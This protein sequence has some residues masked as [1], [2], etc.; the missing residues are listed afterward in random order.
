MRVLFVALFSVFAIQVLADKTKSFKKNGVTVNV[1][2]KDSKLPAGQL[3]KLASTFLTVYPKMM[4][5][6]NPKAVR[7]V[8]LI[9]DPK[10]A[11]F[12]PQSNNTINLPIGYVKENPQDLDIVTFK[13]MGLLLV[14]RFRSAVSFLK[15][16]CF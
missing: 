10:Y 4:R 5:E 7:E 13:A 2:D 1:I 3:Q 15:S 16:C 9:F 12:A 14:R 8:N 6:Y 11:G